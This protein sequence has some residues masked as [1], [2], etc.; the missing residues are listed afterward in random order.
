MIKVNNSMINKNNGANVMNN[1]AKEAQV[2]KALDCKVE[3]SFEAIQNLKSDK[4]R[5][6]QIKNPANI[7]RTLSRLGY[8]SG[9]MVG[10]ITNLIEVSIA[11]MDI[12]YNQ[13][14]LTAGTNNVDMFKLSK[15]F[16]CLNPSNGKIDGYSE[17]FTIGNSNVFNLT[18]TQDRKITI[19]KATKADINLFVNKLKDMKTATQ[20]DLV[21]IGRDLEKIGR[22]MQELEIDS[23]KDVTKKDGMKEITEFMSTFT[24]KMANKKMVVTNNFAEIVSNKKADNKHKKTDLKFEYKIEDYLQLSKIDETIAKETE[25]FLAN[26]PYISPEDK[27]KG[28][29]QIKRDA[30]KETLIEC[31]LAELKAYMVASQSNFFEQLVEMYSLHADYKLFET[32]KSLDIECN[33][34][35]TIDAVRDMAMNCFKMIKNNLSYSKYIATTK[36]DE[37][38]IVLRNAY[39]T[40]AETKGIYADDAFAIACNAAWL[41]KDMYQGKI[42]TNASEQFNYF[43]LSVMFETE[44]K[45]FFN[46]DAMEKIVEVELPDGLDAIKIGTAF[47]FVDGECEVELENGELDFIFTTEEVFTG[48]LIAKSVN[49]QPAFV[50]SSDEFAFDY[51]DFM[52]FDSICDLTAPTNSFKAGNVGVQDLDNITVALKEESTINKE[53]A[54]KELIQRT[55]A[56][57]NKEIF[58]RFANSIELS[59]STEGAFGLFPY[60]KKEE[61]YL[62]IRK[63]ETKSSRMLGRLSTSYRT[64]VMAEYTYTNTIINGAGAITILK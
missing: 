46:S 32:F 55:N 33:D 12:Q 20:E 56:E 30:L 27:T 28:L 16:T 61:K 24:C 8:V 15:V 4:T 48:V 26:N 47:N 6:V 60:S 7:V 25:K 58:T 53:P 42:V 10:I 3:N 52:M 14:F 22:L 31:P 63:V 62:A 54:I 64:K 18:N 13:Q 38:A 23:A 44:L 59:I 57:R 19:V 17:I 35:E 21:K 39:Y 51:V 41:K 5:I 11:L 2:S 45:W 37:M 49:G 9:S 34:I 1:K 43:S 50:E 40:F 29:N 36:L